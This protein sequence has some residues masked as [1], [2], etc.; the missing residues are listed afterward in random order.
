MTQYYPD[1]N[2]AIRKR[3][4]GEQISYRR[5]YG[6]YIYTPRKKRRFLGD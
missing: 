2:A 4:K 6:F 1:L 3:K 5:G